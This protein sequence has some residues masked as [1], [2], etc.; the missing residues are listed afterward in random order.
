MRPAARAIIIHD[1]KVLVLKRSNS[2]GAK[3]MVTPG[4]R[5]EPGETPEE[6]VLREV[7]EETTVIVRNPRLVFTEE[8]L[9]SRWGRQYIY[10]CEYVSGNPHLNPDSE[11]YAY[12]QEGEGTYEPLWLSYDQLNSDEYPFRSPQLGEAL[13]D[14]LRNGFPDQVVSW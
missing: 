6:A 4:G 5:L 11:E 9:D 1:N 2:K 3:Y 10:V 12:Q 14:A 13:R 8:P 7:A